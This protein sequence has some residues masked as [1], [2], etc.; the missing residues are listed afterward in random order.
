M[1][2]R[3]TENNLAGIL[4]ILQEHPGGLS[5]SD[6]AT[7]LT[8][9]RNSV[10][11][12]L[13][14]LQ[15][16]GSVDMRLVGAAKVYCPSRRLPVTAVHR[17]CSPNLIVVDHNLEVLEVSGTLAGILGAT[18]K[19]L[20]GH[21]VLPLFPGI[22]S[23]D[24]V[25]SLLRRALWGEEGTFRWSPGSRRGAASYRVSLIPT[26]LETGRPAVSLVLEKVLEDGDPGEER[27]LEASRQEAL[28]EDRAEGIVRVSPDGRA[29]WA[30]EVYCRMTGTRRDDLIGRQFRPPLV[31]EEKTA[32]KNF[33]RG[34]TPDNPSAT[35]DCRMVMPDGST[36]YYRWRGRALCSPDGTILEYQYLCSD[37][38]G[39]RVI[40]ETLRRQLQALEQET[41][42]REGAL[43]ESE[44]RF[45]RIFED[46]PIGIAV[47]DSAGA[48]LHANRAC[49]EL[50]GIARLDDV[51]GINLLQVCR[52]LDA[53]EIQ[54]PG[55][56]VTPLDCRFDFDRVRSQDLLPTTRTGIIHV[57]GVVS[58]LRSPDDGGPDGC[59]IQVHDVTGRVLAEGALRESHD[60]LAGIVRHL[61][62][63]M[64]AI[65][66][67]GVVTAWNLAMEELTGITAEEILGKGN[68][69]YALPFYGKRTA[70]LVDK[71]L[72]PDVALR[73]R[74][75]FITYAE[76]GEII[77]E[78]VIPPPGGGFPW[79]WWVKAG[80]LY[81]NRGEIV[82][83]IESIRDI[84]GERRAERFQKWERIFMDETGETPR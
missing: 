65:D 7:L 67:G 51:R 74:Y 60:R 73:N 47:C 37:S 62:D 42:D 49:L 40:E 24:D 15:R 14:I 10:S 71:V 34:L 83:A 8:M 12:Y 76:G 39:F 75:R 33:V 66:R 63:A 54:A 35:I 53:C 78:S 61:P 2:D 27:L 82:G 58:P 80:P 3:Q 4:G 59:L 23:S 13:A 11:K 9:N 81:D 46:S 19:A 52:A 41:H 1:V 28:Q 79:I 72:N 70:M 69:D 30:D 5:I 56:A 36:H 16:Q 29:G 18:P 64:F 38:H 6:I 21:P 44:E 25:T 32:W 31:E 68:H 22:S 20:I 55:D 50:F 43:R 84:T 17:F 26:V 45:R 48:L 57:G 77:A